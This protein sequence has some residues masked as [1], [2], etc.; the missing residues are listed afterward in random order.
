M[1]QAAATNTATTAANGG[2]MQFE[3]RVG[4]GTVVTVELK[5]G[6]V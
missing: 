2:T 1:V 6:R 3:S 4:N 5:G